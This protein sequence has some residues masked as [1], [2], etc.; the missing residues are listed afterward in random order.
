MLVDSDDGHLPEAVP[1]TM[2]ALVAARLD[3][4]TD[5]ARAVIEAAAVEGKEF[6][7]E[8]LE[9]L[10]EDDVGE[11]LLTLVRTDL[12]R[13]C[14]PRDGTFRFRHQLIRDAAYDGISKE[15]R[16]TLHERFADWLEQHRA[17]IPSVD[18][19]LGHHLESAV[20]LRRELGTT[21]QALAGLAARASLNLRRAGRR[22]AAREEPA[23]AVRLLERSDLAR[24]RRCSRRDPRRPRPRARRGR[25]AAA[26]LMDAR[27]AMRL[28]EA[29]A[30]RHALAHA[31]L[32]E[33]LVATGGVNSGL[34]H[35]SAEAT[36]RALIDEFEALGDDEGLAGALRMMGYIV[37]DRS[38][39]AAGYLERALV[40]AERAG[41]EEAFMGG[42][43]P[44]P[45]HGLRAAARASRHRALQSAARGSPTCAARAPRWAALKRCCWRC[46]ATSTGPAPSTTRPI[47][48]SRTCTT[49][50]CR[51]PPRSR[52]RISSSLRAL[53]SAQRASPATRWS[54]TRRCTTTTRLDRCGAA[55]PCAG[56][57][58][59]GRRS[60]G[61][62]RPR[63]QMGRRR[64]HFFF[65]F[66]SRRAPV[67]F[68][69]F[70]FFLRGIALTALAEVLELAD[71]TE[72]A[73]DALREALSGHE[74]K[75][76]VVSAAHVLMLI[77]A[78]VAHS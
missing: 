8:R 53:P 48:S 27:E 11:Q 31:R 12:I 10:V 52:A 4:L 78:A 71:R 6:G 63:R 33:L 37:Q 46:A 75:G 45:R 66:F 21:D 41:M 59:Q 38:E 65:F 62:R 56:R 5:P 28:A 36:G 42:R 14:G 47:A 15:R 74:R 73:A 51:R 72:Q 20:V 13:P 7:R 40:H 69:F 39:E 60:V 54:A 25:R 55:G 64:R 9:V 24:A 67:F 32:I 70:F 1:P 29:T 26:R 2:H 77:E 61:V 35:G 44:R 23:A 22:A 58:G 57:A 18:E 50:C 19:L 49:A 3:R 16:A 68:F 30:D 76:N 43:V 17:A 34:D